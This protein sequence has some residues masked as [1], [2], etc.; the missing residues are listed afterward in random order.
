MREQS[1][2]IL[3]LPDEFIR[4]NIFFYSFINSRTYIYID[5]AGNKPLCAHVDNRVRTNKKRTA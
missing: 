1:G 2:W 4:Y 3:L 5:N